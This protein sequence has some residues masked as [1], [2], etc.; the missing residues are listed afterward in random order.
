MKDGTP[1]N[2]TKH[3][4]VTMVTLRIICT[5]HIGQIR[6]SFPDIHLTHA[7]RQ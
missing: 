1:L 6:A 5:D 2:A 7:L 3:I 4:H